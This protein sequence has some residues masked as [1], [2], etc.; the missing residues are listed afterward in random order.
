[1]LNSPNT[2]TRGKWFFACLGICGVVT[3]CTSTVENAAT[4]GCQIDVY[5]DA[6]FKGAHKTFYGRVNNLADVGFNDK[7]SSYEVSAGH[8][9]F[10]QDKDF[11]GWGNVSEPPGNQPMGRSQINLQNFQYVNDEIS[12]MLCDPGP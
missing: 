8:W 6:A 3:A 7:M 4:S 12:S 10:F 11:G 2:F 9:T 5:E 1:M